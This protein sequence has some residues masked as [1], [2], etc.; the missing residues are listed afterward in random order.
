MVR[1]TPIVIGISGV[2][3]VGKTTLTHALAKKLKSTLLCWDDF[4]DISISPTDYVDWYH[5]GR[6][7]SAWDYQA[8]A[9]VLKSLK[10]KQSILHPVFNHILQSTE[11]IIFDAPLGRLHS[12][13]GQYIDICIHLSVPL[14]ISLCRR[15]LRD[16]KGNEKTKEDLLAELEYYLSYSRPLFFDEDL[17]VEAPVRLVGLKNK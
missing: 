4:D 10:A 6:N 17:K 13:T 15:L 14:D 8:L 9:D 7:Y 5:R 3:G 1:M 2:T 11:Y 12:Q 16:F